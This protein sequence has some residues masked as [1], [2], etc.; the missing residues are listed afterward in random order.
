MIKITFYLLLLL[1][2]QTASTTSGENSRS[3]IPYY[4][5][6]NE[7]E[8]CVVELNFNQ[9]YKIYSKAFE[10]FDKHQRT[11]LYN[12]SLCAILTGNNHQAKLWIKELIGLGFAL[13]SFKGNIFQQLPL[14]EWDDIKSVYDSLHNV[15]R[16]SLDLT[17]LAALDTMRIREQRLVQGAQNRYDSLLY[18]HAKVLHH[19]ITEKGIP[20]GTEFEE[21]PL[22]LDVF[23]HH[24]G[25]R[26]R[27]KYN[28][29]NG[30]D[31]VAEPY[32]SMCFKTYDLETLLKEAVFRGELSPN[33]VAACID[34]SELDRT[35]QQGVFEI[36]IDLNTKTIKYLEP[37]PKELE[38]ID[39]QRISLG[40]ESCRD[41]A[42]KDIE[43]AL[44][45]NQEKYPFDELIRR[46]KEIGYSKAAIIA[47]SNNIV[48]RDKLTMAF[49][50]MVNEIRRE[51]LYNENFSAKNHLENNPVFNKWELLK[52]FRLTKSIVVKHIEPLER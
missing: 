6:I 40:L 17:Y 9:A 45:Y 42:K 7:A 21:Q 31:T 3:Y 28:M 26:N 5:A 15:Y 52:Q 14:N 34:H 11:D 49:L 4:K 44:Y 27:L 25:L 39:A 10:Q 35:K 50:D 18:M 20:K 36:S 12:A 8:L 47:L 19:L 1:F 23:R 37:E 30:I 33:F 29:L 2:L 46:S 51:I 43:V 32:K 16:A 41:A 48:E 13:P 24:F 22:P 38:L